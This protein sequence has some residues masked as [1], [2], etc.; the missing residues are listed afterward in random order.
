MTDPPARVIQTFE[1]GIKALLMRGAELLLVRENTPE[2]EWELPGGR[3]DVGEELLPPSEVLRREIREE[4]GSAIHFDVEGPAL[5][6]VRWHD[7]PRRPV[8]LVAHR[9]RCVSGEITLSAEHL[10]YR[11]VD[12][13]GTAK[14]NL[15]PGY[16]GALQSFWSQW[17]S[18]AR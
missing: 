18:T 13:A 4:L 7:P 6:W 14:L 5:A 10:E 17:R 15:A 8:F 16:A 3:I 9:C 11:W 1:V 12:E 2:R